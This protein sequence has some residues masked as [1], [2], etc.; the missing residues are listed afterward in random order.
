VDQTGRLLTIEEG[1]RT[2]GWGAEILAR[3]AEDNTHMI[4]ASRVAALD[5]PVPAAPALEKDVLPQVEDIIA[6]VKKMV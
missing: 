1:T 4:S 5:L 2:L 3:I 6:A